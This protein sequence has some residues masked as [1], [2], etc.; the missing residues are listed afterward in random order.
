[1]WRCIAEKCGSCHDLLDNFKSDLSESERVCHCREYCEY[2][3]G[4]RLFEALGAEEADLAVVFQ[5]VSPLKAISL[6]S[7]LCSSGSKVPQVRRETAPA[8]LGKQLWS[9]QMTGRINK[10]R[11]NSGP[12]SQLPPTRLPNSSEDSTSSSAMR[13]LDN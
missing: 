3:Y 11:R 4:Q 12:P 5:K 13:P 7:D 6:Y 9:G 1:M 8:L 2:M 10:K